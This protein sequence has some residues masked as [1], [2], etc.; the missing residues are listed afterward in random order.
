PL[1]ARF[2]ANVPLNP[3]LMQSDKGVSIVPRRIVRGTLPP[4]RTLMFTPNLNREGAPY[5]QFE[6]A[7]ALRDHGVIEP[8]V[9]SFR[10]GPLRDLY[11]GIGIPVHVGAPIFTEIQTLRRYQL[12][13]ARLGRFIR[14]RNADL[15]YANTLL[16]FPAIDAAERAR[17]PSLWNPRESEPWETYF[18]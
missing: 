13:V 10:D 17:V 9:V 3:N 8:E 16:N 15:V 18:G 1:L 6:L 14:R 12:V 11:R 4:I 5:S 2:E 7:R